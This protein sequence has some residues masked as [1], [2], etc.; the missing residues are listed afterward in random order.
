VDRW[1][2]EDT[3]PLSRGEGQR[4]PGTAE[5][6][7]WV[8]WDAPAWAVRSLAGLGGEGRRGQS[9]HRA[10]GQGAKGSA[11]TTV[12]QGALAPL[13]WA[14]APVSGSEGAKLRRSDP[15]SPD[16]PSALAFPAPSSSRGGSLPP[17]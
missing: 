13:P 3:S 1:V 5:M 7:R 16:Q 11:H 14:A 9:H 8:E 4:G 2:E 6:D 17:P 12:S 10:P 15:S